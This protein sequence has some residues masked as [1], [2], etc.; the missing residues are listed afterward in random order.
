MYIDILIN[1][2]FKLYNTLLIYK[3][4]IFQVCSVK[5]AINELIKVIPI[6]NQKF[7]FLLYTF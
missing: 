5:N 1:K 4:K 2:I 7:Y 6:I 3:Y